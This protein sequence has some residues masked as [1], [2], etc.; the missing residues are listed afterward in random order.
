MNP[1]LESMP[2]GGAG[3]PTRVRHQVVGL[4]VLLAMVTYLD[5][6]CIATLAPDI[7]KSLR[8]SK[9]QMSYVYSAFAVAYAVFE[10]PTAWWADRTGTR[11]VLT[12]SWYG[13][14]ASPSPPRPRSTSPLCS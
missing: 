9:D 7:M 3:R 6:A 12:A 10:I 5:R 8:L 13:G 1:V 11:V 2:G 14:R 4:A